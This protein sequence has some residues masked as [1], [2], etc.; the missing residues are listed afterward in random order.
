[1]RFERYLGPLLVLGLMGLPA[2]SMR[3]IGAENENS[4]NQNQNQNQN[5]NSSTV[6]ILLSIVDSMG[7]V[8]QT[9]TVEGMGP[10]TIAPP[11]DEPDPAE[12]T[13]VVVAQAEGFY[14]RLFSCGYNESI[15]VQLDQ[16]PALHQ[17]LTG[18]VIR[19]SYFGPP[20]YLAEATFRVTDP[21]SAVS[22]LGIDTQGRYRVTDGALG[23]WRFEVQCD[24]WGEP[25]PSVFELPNGEG[26]DYRDLI[27]AFDMSAEAPNLYLYPER[28]TTVSVELGFP[29]G[30]E[31]IL[32]EPPYGN[33]WSV[34]VAPDGT[35]DGAFP[36]LFYE[37]RLPYHVQRERGWI[38]AAEELEM[39]FTR[40]LQEQGFLGREITD[41]LD[42]WLPR[43]TGSPWY[44][45]FPMLADELVTLDIQPAPDRLRR[46]WL[47]L[48]PLAAP[49]SIAP[50]SPP[51][52]LPRDGFVAVEWGAFLSR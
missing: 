9:R 14:T 10:V 34:T 11:S 23:T 8:V 4:T 43:M 47:Y 39:G 7:E 19:T 37:A 38:L 17:A 50:P 1:M 3:G 32:S 22:T 5:Q 44:G 16:V 31:V 35:I 48:E 51:V 25:F 33:G 45:V 15:D 6:E 42:Y 21:A 24:E 26:T 18:V 13:Y 36:Y 27:V 29:R 46:L 12:T 30:G 41:F 20:S 52:P 2:C 28:T 40:L 49:V